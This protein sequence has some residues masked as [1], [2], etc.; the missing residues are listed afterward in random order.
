MVKIL[1]QQIIFLTA[2]YIYWRYLF[3]RYLQDITLV[4]CMTFDIRWRKKHNKM[5]S[6]YKKNKGKCEQNREFVYAELTKLVLFEFVKWFRGRM[7]AS[8]TFFRAPAASRS[9]LRDRRLY[10]TVE[11]YSIQSDIWDFT[12][13]AE[14]N[15]PTNIFKAFQIYGPFSIPTENHFFLHFICDIRNVWMP[16]IPNFTSWKFLFDTCKVNGKRIQ[17]TA[18][19]ILKHFLVSPFVR[20]FSREV[21]AKPND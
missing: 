10:L 7:A 20:S 8:I 4:R 17:F 15:A 18:S 1:K 11:W 16:P 12:L 19:S 14:T 13:T 21:Q 5:F 9:T 6:A 3:W 2:E